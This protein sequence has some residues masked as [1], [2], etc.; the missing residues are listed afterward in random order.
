MHILTW[1]GYFYA[2]KKWS[3]A[4]NYYKKTDPDKLEK[5]QWGEYYFKQ[6]YAYFSKD[7]FEQAKTSFYVIK[8]VDTKYTAPALYYYSHIH[9]EQGNYQ[10]AL[11]GFLKLTSDKTFG[12]IAPYYIVQIYFKQERYKEIVDFAPGMIS[13][14][15]EK[16][17]T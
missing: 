15:T 1:L 17:L 5:E 8:D 10:T 2:R 9:Y 13:K 16:R 4:I 14:V 12:P 6:G 11:D 3:D 7:D